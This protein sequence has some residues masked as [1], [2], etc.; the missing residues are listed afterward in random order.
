MAYKDKDKQR[1]ADRER[2]RH[3]RATRKGVTSEGVTQGVTEGVTGPSVT[4]TIIPEQ[5]AGKTDPIEVIT[6]YGQ[7]DCECIHCRQARKSQL[8]RRS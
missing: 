2:Q 5:Q 4:Q 8:T 3:Y 7:P 6:N 1:A